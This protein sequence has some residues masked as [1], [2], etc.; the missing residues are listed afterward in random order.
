MLGAVWSLG[1]RKNTLKPGKEVW[2]WQEMM[3]IETKVEVEEM[4]GPI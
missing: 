1:R 2:F 4:E 3:S